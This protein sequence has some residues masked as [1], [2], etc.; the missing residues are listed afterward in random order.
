MNKSDTYI[1][2]KEAADI[3]S[4][5][6]NTLRNTR[7]Q[8]EYPPRHKFGK[9]LYYKLSEV[10]DC[11]EYRRKTLALPDWCEENGYITPK[12]AA[13]ILGVTVTCVNTWRY[14]DLGPPYYKFGVPTRHYRRTLYKR[15]EVINWMNTHTKRKYY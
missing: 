3:L 4:L 1:T 8:R 2:V 5:S 13:E 9:R 14:K 11:L 7:N 10:E 15:D 12:E 6:V